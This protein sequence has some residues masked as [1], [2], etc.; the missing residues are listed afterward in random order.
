MKGRIS[1][2]HQLFIKRSNETLGQFC[3][4]SPQDCPC[5]DWC[6]HF[7]EPRSINDHDHNKNNINYGRLLKI[8]ESAVVIDICNGKTLYFDTLTD[9]RK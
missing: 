5:G 4:Y 1:K 7:S 8:N 3:P 6:P 2:S 9:E